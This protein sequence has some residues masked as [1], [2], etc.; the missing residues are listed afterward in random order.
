VKYSLFI[1]FSSKSSE[2]VHTV[3]GDDKKP[4]ESTPR[5][6][7]NFRNETVSIWLPWPSSIKIERRTG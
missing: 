2:A 1:T 3:E 6:E 5:L 4:G 7:G